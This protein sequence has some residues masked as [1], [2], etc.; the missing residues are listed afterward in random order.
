MKAG[1]L[2]TIASVTQRSTVND[3]EGIHP[4]C[5]RVAVAVK[6]SAGV[7]SSKNTTTASSTRRSGGR[8]GTSG[9]IASCPTM[10]KPA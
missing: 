6:N 1:F 4:T 9:R 8:F 10:T 5:V 3:G 2:P 7:T